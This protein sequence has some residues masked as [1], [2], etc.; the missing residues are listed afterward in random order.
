MTPEVADE[1]VPAAPLEGPEPEAPVVAPAVPE[2]APEAEPPE[3]D[4]KA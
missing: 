1:M 2:A 3:P 4:P